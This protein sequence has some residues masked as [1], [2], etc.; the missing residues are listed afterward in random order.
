M[1]ILIQKLTNVINII[2]TTR[3]AGEQIINSLG[4]DCVAKVQHKEPYSDLINIMDT[5]GKPTQSLKFDGTLQVQDFG[6]SPVVFVGTID[7]LVNKLNDEYFDNAS[8]SVVSITKSDIEKLKTEANDLVQTISY[9]DATDP[10]NRRVTTIVYSST[11]LGLTAT[12]TYSYGGSAGDYYITSI[13]L[14]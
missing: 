1:A 13:I 9:L 3:A 8:T 10:V 5:E 4:V 6:G 12:E 11:I 2:E 7:D 14:S